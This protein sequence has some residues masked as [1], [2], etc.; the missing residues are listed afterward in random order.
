MILES[1]MTREDEIRLHC[2]RASAELDMALSAQSIRAARAHFSLTALHLDRMR[3]L[4]DRTVEPSDS[5][6]ASE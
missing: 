1:G 5:I 3:D 6:L 4:A 2:D